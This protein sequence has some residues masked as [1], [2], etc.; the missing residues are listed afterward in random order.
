M[1]QDLLVEDTWI[2]KNGEEQTALR[3]VGVSFTLKG[4]GMRHKI[5]RNVSIS[6]E[7]LSLPQKKKARGEGAAEPEAED[8]GDDF[9]E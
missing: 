9:L 1:M 3:K 7:C 6:G 8:A 4:G 5:Y 2:D